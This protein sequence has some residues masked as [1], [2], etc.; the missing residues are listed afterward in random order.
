MG[1]HVLNLNLLLL[2]RDLKI[3][4]KILSLAVRDIRFLRH[5]APETRFS[6]NQAC[7]AW[8]DKNIKPYDSYTE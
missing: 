6:V 8:A 1:F 7:I 5:L 2:F 4:Y 3:V